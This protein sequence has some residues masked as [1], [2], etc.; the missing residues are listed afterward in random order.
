MIKYYAPTETADRNIKYAFYKTLERNFNSITSHSIKIVLGDMN[1]QV[2]RERVFE[3]TAGK[4]CL[5]Q[6][7]NNNG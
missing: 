1:A 7:S 5:H 3:K 6:Q 4:E 2:G